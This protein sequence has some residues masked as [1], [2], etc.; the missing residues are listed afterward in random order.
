MYKERWKM[1]T[2]HLTREVEDNQLW[3]NKV[4]HPATCGLCFGRKFSLFR[5]LAADG[6]GC[7]PAVRNVPS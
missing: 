7:S 6:L 3:P 1:D 5:P 4:L 2:L